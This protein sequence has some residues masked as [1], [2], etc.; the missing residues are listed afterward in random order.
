MRI[1]D[2]ADIIRLLGRISG[3]SAQGTIEAR[4]D[5]QPPLHLDP[6]Q[7]VRG[8]VLQRLAGG[9][10]LVKIAGE[11]LDMNLPS[12]V[13]PG[14]TVPLTFIGD[15]PRLTF[16]L[17]ASATSGQ[18]ANVSETARLLALLSRTPPQNEPLST[19]PLLSKQEVSSGG[20]TM[21]AA[22]LRE[23]LGESGVFYESH[24]AEWAAGKRDLEELQ[25]EPQ[26]RLSQ[27]KPSSPAALPDAPERRRLTVIHGEE[28]QKPLAAQ[29][30]R[31]T[32]I[33]DPQT[34][35]LV[36]QQLTLLQGGLFAWNG[37]AWPGQQM[38]WTVGEREPEPE[39][40][41]VKQWQAS[42][43]LDL[44]E[45]GNV[46][47]HLVLIE[48]KLTVALNVERPD[49]E[50]RMEQHE[51][52]LRSELSARGICLMEMVVSREG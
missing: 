44:P 34:L 32:E 48:G 50:T 2:T 4:H 9:R 5:R 1:V 28:Q 42:V 35:P 51:G 21:L 10:F 30:S 11:V 12:T 3:N 23:A 49:T 20:A 25:R 47:A 22:R 13:K 7:E 29:E 14:E 16:S 18:P 27:R 8:E 17:G 40:E 6:G 45:L 36:R 33:A 52:K 15:K 41:Q 26:G 43:K 46:K 19:L 31:R 38:E 24:L 39:K 37:E